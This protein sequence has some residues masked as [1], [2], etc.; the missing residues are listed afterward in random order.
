MKKRDFTSAFESDNS[1]SAGIS[2]DDAVHGLAPKLDTGRIV[3]RPISIFDIYPDPTQ[4]R[5]AVPSS[6]RQGWNGDPAGVERVLAAW[7]SAVEAESG[8]PFDLDAY[9]GMRAE[10]ED[11]DDHTL[12][13]ERIGPIK[14]SFCALADLAATIYRDG[15]TN[16]ITVAQRSNQMAATYILETGERRWL[17]YHLLRANFPQDDRWKKIPARV[18]NAP[19][20]WRQAAENNARDNL[21]AIAKARQ[22]AILLMDLWSKDEKSPIQFRPF[23]S[24]EN[25]REYYAQVAD[26]SPP[27][28]K[29]ELILAAM[30]VEHRNATM[31]YKALLRLPDEVWRLA[32]D[33]NWTEG[34]LRGLTK[35]PPD[36]AIAKARSWALQEDKLSPVGDK[37][38][39]KTPDF[40]DKKL[41]HIEHQLSPKAIKELSKDEK[42]ALRNR[43]T[44]HRAWLDEVERL[45]R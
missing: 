25:E 24:F 43:L 13:P 10:G 35:L 42:E 21:N 33:R 11:E 23:D 12:H 26:M 7:H 17:A 28:G 5:R 9:L 44:T 2:L 8:R 4:P 1:I 37:K 31:R 29:N 22:Y 34:R 38:V 20:L 16:P 18:V 41:S 40:W 3:A 39:N 36:I 19:N 27:K 45:L 15:L 14:A 6:V 30:G 32:D